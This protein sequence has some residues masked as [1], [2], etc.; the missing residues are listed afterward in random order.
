[1]AGKVKI[2]VIGIGTM[3]REHVKSLQT[4]D[5]CQVTA[6]CDCLEEKTKSLFDDGIIGSEVAVF[7]SF[8]KLIGSGLC[9]AVAVVTPHPMHP[10]IAVCAF[11][12]GLHVMCDKPIAITA[13]DAGRMIAAWEKTNLK[14]STMYSMRTEACNRIIKEYLDNDRLGTLRRVE[15]VCT[16][17]LRSQ[18]YYDSQSWR[19]TWKDEGGGLLMNQAPHNLD[20]LAWWFGAASEIEANVSNRFHDIET[21]DEVSATVWMKSGFP[22]S[23][24]AN[25]A[26]APGR[27]YVEIVGDKGTLIR[28]NGKLLF[29]KLESSLEETVRRSEESFPALKAEDTELEIPDR[30]YG[31]EVVLE[32]F[33]DAIIN[34]CPNNTMISPGNEGIN[35]VEWAN[36][37]L[38][39]AFTGKTVKLPLDR[40]AYDDL[41]DNL[42]SG[43]IKLDG[44]RFTPRK[45]C[46]N[47]KKPASER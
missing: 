26:E 7:T 34:D 18:K 29:R 38:L 46:G 17:W 41:L 15:M 11:E 25:T 24:Y 27:D 19:G 2:G 5:S 44:R 47:R 1:M 36:A 16:K 12:A 14:F 20:L 23:F 42:R 8:E 37:M 3:G 39:S 40:G 45:S 33:L 32:S 35:A 13:S 31:S 4:I 22:I 10:G 21:E 28:D 43:K 30:R 6:V 9:E